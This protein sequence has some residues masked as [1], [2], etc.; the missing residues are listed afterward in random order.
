[1]TEVEN[2]AWASVYLLSIKVFVVALDS[3]SKPPHVR[4]EYSYEDVQMPKMRRVDSAC[5]TVRGRWV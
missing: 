5:E 4:I 3:L 2:A 1:M